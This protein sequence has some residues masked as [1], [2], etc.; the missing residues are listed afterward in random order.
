[1]LEIDSDVFTF[2]PELDLSRETFVV[3]EVSD[4]AP[5]LAALQ[6]AAERF[7]SIDHAGVEHETDESLLD[8]GEDSASDVSDP[9]VTGDGVQMYVDSKG[10]IP[11]PMAATMRAVLT[12]ELAAVGY[13]GR[14]R[15]VSPT[16]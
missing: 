9:E 4:S 12:E 7:M 2:Q 16:S 1:M 5:I 3:T 10:Y 13:G 11:D 8:G 14:V 15:A 6:K